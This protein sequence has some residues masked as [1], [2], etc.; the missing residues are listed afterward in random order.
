MEWDPKQFTYA[1]YPFRSF[2]TLLSAGSL[3]GLVYY[4]ILGSLLG[5]LNL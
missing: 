5:L 3:L 4:I 2:F 1:S